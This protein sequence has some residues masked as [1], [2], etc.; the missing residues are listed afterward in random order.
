MTEQTQPTAGIELND[1]VAVVRLIDTVSQRGAFRGEELA[2]VGI[3]RN[4]VA[5]FVGAAAQAQQEAAGDENVPETVVDTT[6]DAQ[7]ED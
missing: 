2:E 3:L 7:A 1:L 5:G 6:E 4:K